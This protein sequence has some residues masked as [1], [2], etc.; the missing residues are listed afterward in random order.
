M[1]KK[2]LVWAAFFV[3]P[4]TP[5]G[6]P[7]VCSFICRQGF[8]IVARPTCWPFNML[9]QLPIL[10]PSLRDYVWHRNPVGVTG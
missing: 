1:T 5:T 3:F 7:S 2:S 9:H 8:R 6:F 10:P 4:F